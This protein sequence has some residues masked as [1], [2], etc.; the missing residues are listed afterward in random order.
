MGL[1]DSGDGSS[2]DICQSSKAGIESK[3]AQ[4]KRQ[5]ALGRL[6]QT[7]R[8]QKELNCKCPVERLYTRSVTT[9]SPGEEAF[10]RERMRVKANK[11]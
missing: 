5:I 3:G 1:V 8:R 4:R 2:L 10:A 9:K 6:A 7:K 11:L